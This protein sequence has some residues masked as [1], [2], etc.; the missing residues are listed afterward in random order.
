[1]SHSTTQEDRQVVTDTLPKGLAATSAGVLAK[2]LLVGAGAGAFTFAKGAYATIVQFTPSLT[3][4]TSRTIGHMVSE[5]ISHGYTSIPYVVAM[6]NLQSLLNTPPFVPPHLAAVC[7]NLTVSTL[8]SHASQSAQD[9][10]LYGLLGFGFFGV[11]YMWGKTWPP[12][13][14]GVTAQRQVYTTPDKE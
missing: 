10:A 9:A 14:S 11:R 8:W 13:T 2:A 3:V 7:H 1:M 5:L 12:I 4:N 6:C